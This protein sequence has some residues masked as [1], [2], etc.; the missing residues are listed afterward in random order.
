MEILNFITLLF[1]KETKFFNEKKDL[2]VIA[3]KDIYKIKV[4][5]GNI[6]FLENE[7]NKIKNISFSNDNFN[8][9]TMI[10]MF[11]VKGKIKSISSSQKYKFIKNEYK[12]SNF[13]E[14]INLYLDVIENIS[15]IRTIKEKKKYQKDIILS[16]YAKHHDIDLDLFKNIEKK[17]NELKIKNSIN[18]SF[19]EFDID[20]I[21]LAILKSNQIVLE[22]NILVVY[23]QKDILKYNFNNV[24]NININNKKTTL[25]KKDINYIFKCLYLKDK[26]FLLKKYFLFN[27]INIVHLP[28]L[29]RLGQDFSLYNKENCQTNIINKK[30]VD[31]KELKSEVKKNISNYTNDKNANVKKEDIFSTNGFGTLGELLGKEKVKINDEYEETEVFK[32]YFK[33]KLLNKKDNTKKD[34]EIKSLVLWDLENIN[35]YNDFSIITRFVKNDNQLKV[36]SFSNK[37]RDYKNTN[38]FNFTLE[39]LKKRFWVINETK[40]IADNVLIENFHKYKHSL[41][42]LIVISNDSDFKDI[43]SEAN[44]LGINTIVLYRHGNKN[45]NYWYDIANE[46]LAL[47]ELSLN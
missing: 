35:Y 23:S 38:S 43:I 45:M 10:L 14:K 25:T 4:N 7:T 28:N 20:Y 15:K 42:E 27:N 46:T 17:E 47:Q 6:E 29:E 30:R 22:N 26:N 3:N 9:L 5:E 16:N 39:K 44:H 2:Y 37:Y 33:N 31:K 36:M 40:K 41:K 32:P 19:N 34:E 1:D 11:I 13:N 21:C 12:S 8:E 24:K 18:F